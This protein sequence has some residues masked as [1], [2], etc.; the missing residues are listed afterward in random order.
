[1]IRLARLAAARRRGISLDEICAEFG[2]SHRTAQRLT[3][4]LEDAFVN[5]VTEDGEDR[6]R[7]WRLAEPQLDRLQLREETGL[8][9]WKSPH[10]PPRPSGASVMQRPLPSCGTG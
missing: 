7:R 1:L 3:D 2:V 9:A 5:V 4:A 10:G 8:E 6:K